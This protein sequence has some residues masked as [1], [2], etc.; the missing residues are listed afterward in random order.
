M[1]VN[2]DNHEDAVSIVHKKM[3]QLNWQEVQ[4]DRIGDLDINKFSSQDTSLTGSFESA[5]EAGFRA[6]NYSGIVESF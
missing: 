5:L 1:F 3:K 6:I 4:M 2:S